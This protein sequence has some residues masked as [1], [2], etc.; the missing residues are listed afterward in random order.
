MS[1]LDKL[2]LG[3]KKKEAPVIGEHKKKKEEES[4]SLRDSN[5]FRVFIFLCFIGV[6]YFL[7]P[8]STFKDI[9]NYEV[10]QPWRDEDLTAPF[11]FSLLK[12]DQEITEEK[13]KIRRLT[14]PIFHIE[15]NAHI[16]IQSR[17]DSLFRN[18]QPV[19][20]SYVQWQRNKQNE[21]TSAVN[22][23][24]RFVQEK[25]LS[26][27][28]LDNDG[29]KALLE[30]FKNIQLNEKQSSRQRFIGID[31][32]L[33]LDHLIN[34]LLN[35]GIINI[36][37]SELTLDEIIVRD[38]KE[39]T[40]RS[41]SVANVRD[42]KEARDYAKYRISRMFLDDVS[43]SAYQIFN[44]VIEPNYIFDAEETQ[45]RINEALETISTTKGAVAKGQVIIRKGDIVTEEKAN[46]LRSL[47]KAK[48]ENASQQE[49][50][51]RYLGD[52]IVII[53][54]LLIFIMYIYNYRPGIFN[55]NMHLLL[56]VL[57]FMVVLA[58][59]SIVAGW[60]GVS[61]YVVPIA[62]APIILTIIFD[63]RVGFMSTISLALLTGLINGNNFE[64]VVATAT[65]S[66][67]GVFSVRDI[68]NRAEFFFATPGM[69]FL[70]YGIV[71]VGFSL[72]R[73]GGWENFL[74]QIMYVGINAIFILFTYPIILLFE[75]IFDVTTDFTLLE[76][77]DTNSDLLKELM[78][79]APGTFHHSLQVSNLAEAAASE[80]GA[81]TLLCRVGAL[82]H[83]IGKMKKPEYFVENQQGMNAHD[84]LKPRMSARVIKAHVSDGVAMAEEKNI[85][86]QIIDFIRT[87]HGTTL[88]KFFYDKAKTNADNEFEIQEEDF[89][90]NGPI[91]FT[92]ET[93]ILLMADC[94]EA[95]SRAMKDANPKK[96]ENL[97][98]RMVEERLNEG[99]LNNCPLNLHEIRKAREAF[100]NILKGIHHG[101]VEYPEDQQPAEDSD[102]DGELTKAVDP[103]ERKYIEAKSA[104][105]EPPQP[106][107]NPDDDTDD[108]SQS[109]N[110]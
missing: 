46:M 26:G 24:I 45:A 50:G 103:E 81:N 64:F 13:E 59:S 79:K 108:I 43:T 55:D 31:I 107:V 102:A 76:L 32:K 44:L 36:S 9:Q 10:G 83:D 60:E 49:L 27:V 75:K 18:M 37:K 14:P 21:N 35:D 7:I 58:P 105:G 77:S 22:D 91:P 82:Y 69:V 109:L 71:I 41:L 20:E 12:T 8:R 62:I 3:R 25:N 38:L 95:S 53:M 80:I 15:H 34:E 28:G 85:P 48:A 63:S 66:T 6:M 19:L 98:D 86:E 90:Y 100:K 51:L 104:D 54:V 93:G 72:T 33:K 11:T 1:I 39:R 99:Q 17:L 57:A 89:R 42:I 101:R 47:A 56:V 73:Y 84:K 67:L 87:H 88:I 106:P 61:E 29:W 96:L 2:G 52:L 30:N 92:K 78:T 74:N 97:V 94:I 65:A 23:S 16:R 68:N 70:S 110:T 40:E 5:V 4:F